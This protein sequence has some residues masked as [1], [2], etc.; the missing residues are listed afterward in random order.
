MITDL[1]LARDPT[2]PAEALRALA[3]NRDLE[4][5]AAVASNPNT[6][7]DVVVSLGATHPRALLAN[8]ALP[9]FLLENPS[10]LAGLPHATARAL[11]TTAP[12]REIALGLTR[13]V[14]QDIRERAAQR[15][16]DPADLAR[17]CDE[18]NHARHRLVLEVPNLPLFVLDKILADPAC[19][20]FAAAHPRAPS[21]AFLVLAESEDPE[22]RLRLATHFRA[23][24]ELL[25]R[26]ASDVDANVRAAVAASP[27][28]PEAAR[29]RLALDPSSSV[30]AAAVLH[31]PPSLL[32]A[33]ALDEAPAVRRALLSRR[34]CPP[35]VRAW[36]RLDAS[37][38]IRSA[39]QSG[40]RR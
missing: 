40:G 32:E 7:V 18:P 22:F 19:A 27:R 31:A 24:A 20:P 33:L 9:F 30:R 3:K 26:L 23:T 14:H 10:F 8:P 13:H 2:A 17:L 1:L 36:L 37:R 25:E 39:A 12:S 35:K 6:P 28:T 11:L 38:K 4:V 29:T 15:L 21:D 16:M 34:D 5:Q